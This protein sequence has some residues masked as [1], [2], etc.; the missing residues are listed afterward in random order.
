MRRV[1]ETSNRMVSLN[2][3]MRRMLTE[4]KREEIT[5]AIEANKL[6]NG[7]DNGIRYDVDGLQKL[8]SSLIVPGSYISIIYWNG[9]FATGEDSYFKFNQSAPY[10]VR[11]TKSTLQVGMIG[12]EPT[13]KLTKP[14]YFFLNNIVFDTTEA[15]EIKQNL[16]TFH[17]VQAEIGYKGKVICISDDGDRIYEL[18]DGTTIKEVDG[19]IVYYKGDEILEEHDINTTFEIK[20]PIKGITGSAYP[21]LWRLY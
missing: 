12:G 7:Y 1:D 3:G 21:I 17:A 15:D 5:N 10:E 9:K 14:G 4:E 19:K 13:L 20:S 18:E 6:Y 16:V 8:N 2:G 11:L